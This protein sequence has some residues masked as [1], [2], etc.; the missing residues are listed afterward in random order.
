MSGVILRGRLCIY[1]QEQSLTRSS[2]AV[3]APYTYKP[4][5][6][7]NPYYHAKAWKSSLHC[8]STHSS[9][10]KHQAKPPQHSTRVSLSQL[11]LIHEQLEHCICIY[12]SCSIKQESGDWTYRGVS[13]CEC[14]PKACPLAASRHLSLQ[15]ERLSYWIGSILCLLVFLYLMCFQHLSAFSSR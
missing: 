8:S 15:K 4:C 7:F 6:P 2:V 1:Y 5:E 12:S 14:L 10:R 3:L 9:D 13:P 11:W